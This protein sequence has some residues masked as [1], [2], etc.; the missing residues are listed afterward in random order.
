MTQPEWKAPGLVG[1]HSLLGDLEHP[2]IK[3]FVFNSQCGHED[4]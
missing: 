1:I 4:E 2:D 3:I